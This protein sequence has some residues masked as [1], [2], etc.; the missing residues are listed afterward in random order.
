MPS[1][2]RR[3]QPMGR[4]GNKVAQGVRQRLL[5]KASHFVATWV[6]FRIGRSSA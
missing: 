2:S 4:A 5:R 1:R 6:P 3:H